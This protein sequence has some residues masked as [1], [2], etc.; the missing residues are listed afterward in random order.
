MPGG[1]ASAV[2]GT[3]TASP[4]GIG[5]GARRHPVAAAAPAAVPGQVKE[6]FFLAVCPT[7]SS[8]RKAVCLLGLSGFE[9]LVRAVKP[10]ALAS[11]PVGSSCSS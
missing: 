2:E 4:L 1:G 10:P 8:Q 6:S 11:P 5:T 3:A 9:V 7:S